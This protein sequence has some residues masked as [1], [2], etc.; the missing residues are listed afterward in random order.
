MKT[1][2]STFWLIEV[3]GT[4]QN[5]VLRRGEAEEIDLPYVF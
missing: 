4:E 5:S 2:N 3:T 1:K